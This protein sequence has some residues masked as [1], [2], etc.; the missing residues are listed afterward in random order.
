MKKWLRKA[1]HKFIIS[2]NGAVSIYAIMITLLL[3]IFNAVLIDYI[4]IMTAE[5][6]VDQAVKA[7]ARSTMSSFDKSMMGSYGLFGF[8]GDEADIFEKVVREHLDT[9]EGDYFRFADTRLV[10]DSASVSFNEDMMVASK[11]TFEYQILEDMK[12]KAPLEIGSAIL[13]GFL[14]VSNEMEE[15][16]NFVDVAAEVQKLI[17]DREEAL[18]KVREEVTKAQEKSKTLETNF[19]G[20]SSRLFPEANSLAVLQ[21]V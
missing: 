2:E 15:A 3:F 8:K 20:S 5:R 21:T 12:Y 1:F 18:E 17:D 13:E 10:D 6:K 16:S 11:D 4:R 9:G 19:E 7:A 14:S